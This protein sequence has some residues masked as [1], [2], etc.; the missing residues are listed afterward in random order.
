MQGVVVQGLSNTMFEQ[1]VY[2]EN[3][4][5]LTAEFEIYILAKAFQARCRAR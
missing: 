1:V 3:G 5:C 4:Q 2:D